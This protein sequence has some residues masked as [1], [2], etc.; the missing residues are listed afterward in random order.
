[1]NKKTLCILL[2]IVLIFCLSACSSG[3]PK[4][5]CG[6]YKSESSN[7]YI[8]VFEDNTVQIVNYDLSDLETIL[9]NDTIVIAGLDENNAKA[10]RDSWDFNRDYANKSV[11]FETDNETYQYEGTI[12]L[13]FPL[14]NPYD[15]GA[16]SWGISYYPAEKKMLIEAESITTGERVSEVFVLEK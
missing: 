5:T 10:L 2:T 12:G 15:L 14:N 13:T 6:V 9:E 4:I 7:A 16:V 11:K 1:M 8:E 3:V